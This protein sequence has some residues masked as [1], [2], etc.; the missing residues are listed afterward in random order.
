M[1]DKTKKGKIYWEVLIVIGALLLIEIV[2]GIF[3]TDQFGAVMSNMLYWEEITSDG[4]ST[5]CRW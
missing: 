2:L 3:F 1:E 5:F 4:G